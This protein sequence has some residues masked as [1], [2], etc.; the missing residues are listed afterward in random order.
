[1]LGELSQCGGKSHGP[2]ACSQPDHDSLG[3]LVVSPK[4][5]KTGSED[6][7]ECSRMISGL[8]EVIQEDSENS[9]KVSQRGLGGL[10]KC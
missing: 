9:S 2:L 7:S 4:M 6:A 10:R 1:M 8:L 5:I 3:M